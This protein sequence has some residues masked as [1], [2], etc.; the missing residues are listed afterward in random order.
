MQT[1][2]AEG[3]VC[4]RAL[5]RVPLFATLWTGNSPGCSVHG[6]FEARTLEWVAISFSGNR[7]NPE[8]RPVFFMFPALTDEFFTTEPPGSLFMS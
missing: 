4:V 3:V 1:S 8:I 5:H 6:I 2:S 7:P